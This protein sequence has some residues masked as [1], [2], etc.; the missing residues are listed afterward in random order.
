MRKPAIL[1]ALSLAALMSGS[2]PSMAAMIYPN[3]PPLGALHI[4]QRVLVDDGSCKLGYL[5][6]IVVLS[7]KAGDT[8]VYP[9]GGP[10]LARCVAKPSSKR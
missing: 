6:E 8:T 1:F 10:R 9:D 2:V 3:V 5:T 4:G 7:R